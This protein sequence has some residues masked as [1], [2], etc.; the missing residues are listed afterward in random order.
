MSNNTEILNGIRTGNPR[1]FNEG[2]RVRQTP[3]EGRRTYFVKITIKMKT[4]V[5]KPLMIKGPVLFF[6]KDA[7]S[8]K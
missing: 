2:S 4:I 8:I 7:L 1:G 3:E 5:R 6:S